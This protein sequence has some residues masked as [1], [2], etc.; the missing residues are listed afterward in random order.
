MTS[1]LREAR[2]IEELPTLHTS[3]R[4][5]EAVVLARPRQT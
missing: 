2:T 1:S 5:L 4:T 3:H